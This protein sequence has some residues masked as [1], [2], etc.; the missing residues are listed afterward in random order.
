M[1]NN[2]LEPT[3]NKL[4]KTSS[5]GEPSPFLKLALEMG[6]LAV[7]YASNAKGDWLIH[8]ISL[9]H[10]FTKPIFPATALFMLAIIFS[11]IFSLILTKK[12]PIIPLVSS[13][14]VIVFGI[15]TLYLH[16]DVFIKIKPT[17]VNALFGFI[18]LGGLLFKKPLLSYIFDSGFHL[19]IAGWNKL[20]M[21][22]GWYFLFLAAANEAVW[23]NFS[24]QVWTNFKVFYVM[25]I[26]IIFFLCQMPL[27]MK[28][29][30]QPACK[31]N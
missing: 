2:I 31:V 8:N 17:I 5:H 26:T 9:F 20:T 6:P 12:V 22:W 3:P 15:L 19:D 28:H 18:L 24:T 29:M 16:N 30:V 25:P 1:L 13:L 21:R 11:L 23:R 4:D 10:N 7:F 14:F 27:I